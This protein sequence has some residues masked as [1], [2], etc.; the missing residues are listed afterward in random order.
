MVSECS[1][2]RL[3]FAAIPPCLNLTNIAN[4]SS[5]R[6]YILI[7]SDLAGSIPDNIQLNNVTTF[8]SV[9]DNNLT[10]QIPERISN[11]K[12]LD[13]LDVSYNYFT[14]SLPTSLFQ[15]S[16]LKHL[17]LSANPNLD[18]GPIPT[19]L[20]NLTGLTELSFKLSNRHGTLPDITA[21]SNLVYLDLDNNNFHGTI[22]A[23]YGSAP[24]LQYLLLNRNPNLNGTAPSFASATKFVTAFF[25]GTKIVGDLESICSL[26]LFASKS[27]AERVANGWVVVANCGADKDLKCSCCHCCLPQETDSASGTC[28]D[29]AVDTLDWN[30]EDKYVRTARNVG[31]NGSKASLVV[32]NGG[33]RRA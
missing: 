32:S 19:E 13:H 21:L 6:I 25:D 16:P 33:D 10:G 27:L 11:L 14:G 29:L 3:L 8:F 15:M 26:P 18:A 28:S 9:Y 4:N 7:T 17:F 24:E 1:T 31:F 12:S 30:W 20:Q 22:P 23:H 2:N 5:L